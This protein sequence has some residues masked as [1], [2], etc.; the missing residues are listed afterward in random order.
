MS[1]A[2]HLPAIDPST[3]PVRNGSTYPTVFAERVLPREKRALGNAA[4]LTKIGV[5]LTTLC[6]SLQIP[7]HLL[8]PFLVDCSKVRIPLSEALVVE[9]QENSF[10]THDHGRQP[11][12][13][14]P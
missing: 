7:I 8:Q 2:L 1:S 9:D 5:N 12:A 3:L 6:L 4:G 14:S 13:L 10:A 11:V